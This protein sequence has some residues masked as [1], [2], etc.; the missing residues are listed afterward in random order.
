[1]VVA[2]LCELLQCT[3]FYYLGYEGQVAYWPV[4]CVSCALFYCLDEWF[5]NCHLPLVV[6]DTFV[7]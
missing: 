4:M 1:M 3:F 6:E 2:M 7:K 5:Y